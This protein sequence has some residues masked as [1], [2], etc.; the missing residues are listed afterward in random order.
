MLNQGLTD[1]VSITKLQA[2]TTIGTLMDLVG[3]IIYTVLQSSNI[4]IDY[5]ILFKHA[6]FFLPFIFTAHYDFDF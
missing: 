2:T 1:S 3:E 5:Q 6:R 4:A